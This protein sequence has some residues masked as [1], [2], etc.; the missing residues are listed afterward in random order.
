MPKIF[1]FLNK[2]VHFGDLLQPENSQIPIMIQREHGGQNHGNPA[3]I[4]P[5]VGTLSRHQVE[6]NLM[7]NGLAQRKPIKNISWKKECI[8]QKMETAFRE[9]NTTNQREQKRVR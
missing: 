7:R 9:R 2:K 6:K 8:S 3:A 5:E 4:K 1:Q